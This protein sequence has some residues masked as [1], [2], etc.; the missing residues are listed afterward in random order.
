MAKKSGGPDLLPNGSPTP[1]PPTSLIFA[2]PLRREEPSARLR[3]QQWEQ[4]QEVIS[5]LE[6]W[7][8]RGFHWPSRNL[9]G[10]TR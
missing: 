3:R 2:R 10:F 1:T 6:K 4:L 7:R 9:V 8:D 5:H